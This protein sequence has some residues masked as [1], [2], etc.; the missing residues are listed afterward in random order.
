MFEKL[1]PKQAD[2]NYTGNPLAKW[3]LWALTIVTV[4]RSMVHIF[5]HGGSLQNLTPDM[6][7]NMLF[8]SG[9]VNIAIIIA[10]WGLT[11][12]ILSLVY[13]LVLWRYQALIPFI[14]L[15]MLIECC[16]REY[17]IHLKL[18]VPVVVVGSHAGGHLLNYITVPLSLLMLVIS[19]TTYQRSA[20]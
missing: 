2:N 6:P 20:N 4:A 16:V 9:T 13:L 3:V 1:F 5:I 17:L 7:I 8:Y 15:L 10:L 18:A 12:L 14:Y 11:Q 19:L